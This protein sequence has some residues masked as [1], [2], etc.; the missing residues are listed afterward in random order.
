VCGDSG[1]D[2]DLFKVE[3]VFGVAVSNSHPEL[4]EFAEGEVRGGNDRVLLA[5]RECAGGIVEALGRFGLA[6]E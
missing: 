4:R 1:N 3:G 6:G 2:V 5:S